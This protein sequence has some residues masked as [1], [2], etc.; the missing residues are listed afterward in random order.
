VA[1][2][3]AVKRTVSH[4]LPRESEPFVGRVR[5]SMQEFL[6]ERLGKLPEFEL[7]PMFGGAGMYAGGTMFGIVHGGRAYLKTNEATRAAFEARDMKAFVPRRGA[8]LKSYYE[9]PP[10]VL[11]DE[12]DLLAWAR[13]SLALATSE[14]HTRAR[15]VS[16]EQILDGYVPAVRELADR[17]RAI[18]RAAAPDAEEAGYAGWRL[19][20]YRSPHYFCF[21]APQPDHV[22]LGFEHGKRLPDPDG[23]LEPMGK[24]VRFVR[25]VPGR[26][27][28][29]VSVK[30]LLRAALATPPLARQR[31][32][33]RTKRARTTKK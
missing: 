9:I 21:V 4:R 19:I 26:P 32:A 22:R 11:D 13:Q 16:P 23:V 6:E 24:Q 2:S 1:P 15:T 25:L 17:A 30:R 5:D 7:R 33:K 8:T 3:A 20:G 29:L 31:Q 12:A 27:I 18:V 10:D 28:P 14:R